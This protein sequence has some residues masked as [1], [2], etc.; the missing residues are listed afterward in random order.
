MGWRV[1]H[2]RLNSMSQHDEH[3]L[4]TWEANV[5]PWTRAVRAGEIRSRVAV[6]N[7]AILHAVRRLQPQRLL[8]L[9]CGEGWICHTLAQE[10]VRCVGVDA[11]AGLIDAA[12]AGHPP[13]GT[14]AEYAMHRY[15]DIAAGVM[16]ERYRGAFDVIVCNFAL[17]GEALVP[18]LLRALPALLTPQGHFVLQTLHPVM[19]SREVPYADGWRDGSWAGFSAEFTDPAPWYFRT[20]GSW[21]D[22]LTTSGFS[23]TQL[24]EP[25]HPD[26]GMPASLL[27]TAAVQ[28]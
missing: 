16:L 25:L 4:R 9:G 7:E 14:A 13:A 23:V 1:L 21:I 8:D 22:V 24:H 20:I 27:I 10:G 12:Q 15:E 18:A 5:A 28:N 26:T 6:T 3:I 11:I 2:T 19:A 17:F